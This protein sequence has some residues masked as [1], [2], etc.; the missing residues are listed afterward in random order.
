M[1][2][3]LFQRTCRLRDRAKNRSL[4]LMRSCLNSCKHESGRRCILFADNEGN[5]NLSKTGVFACTWLC[6]FRGFYLRDHACR[7]KNNGVP[8][9]IF[10]LVCLRKPCAV[11][12]RTIASIDVRVWLLWNSSNYFCST[13][14]ALEALWQSCEREYIRLRWIHGSF[15]YWCSRDKCAKWVLL[16]LNLIDINDIHCIFC[17]FEE[18]WFAILARFGN[19]AWA[20]SA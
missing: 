7:G 13:P 19:P 16:V 3:H 17:D 5:Q 20:A 4:E 14:H 12:Q 10:W 6:L 1:T 18:T 11:P 8:R 15:E 2:I 9:I